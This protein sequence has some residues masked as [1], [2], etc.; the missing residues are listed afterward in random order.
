MSIGNRIFLQRPQ[1]NPELLKAYEQLPAANIA[2]TMNRIAVLGNGI[3]RISAPKKPIMAGFA[4]TVKARAGDNLMLHAALDMATKNDVIVVSNEGDRSRAL[5]GEIMVAYAHCCK[6]IAGI[7]LDGPIRDIDALS[8]LDF[9]LFATGAN[10][11]GPFKEG[12][13]E[14]NTPIAVGGV[15]V[16]PG[17]LI[18]GDADGVI[19]VPLGDAEALLAKAKE[20]SKFDAS[21]VE[22]AKNGAANRQ[23]VKKTLEDKGVE[24]IDDTYR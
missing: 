21:K 24:F 3:K 20:Y 8:V 1:G 19:V 13:G 6:K 15:A 4:I 23:W 18:V 17:D 5:M 2:D 12:P 14:V 10:P 11:A 22:A 9:P 16:N 7:V